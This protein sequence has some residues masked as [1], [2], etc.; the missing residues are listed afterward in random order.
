M[1]RTLPLIAALVTVA[2]GG[3]SSE[4]RL[5][6][7]TAPAAAPIVRSALTPVPTPPPQ[8]CLV[9]RERGVPESYAPT[10][11]VALPRDYTLGPNIRLR[12]EAARAAIKLIDAAWE[13]GHKILAESGYRSFQEQL[14]L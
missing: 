5:K 2:C 1:K 4:E 14:K 3:A 6:I 9:T 10:D 7:A 8:L 13:D 12:P 11:L